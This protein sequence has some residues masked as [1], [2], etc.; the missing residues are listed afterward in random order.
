[1][2]HYENR[3]REG[4][5]F[6]IFAINSKTNWALLLTSIRAF[7]LPEFA[8]EAVRGTDFD[9]AVQIKID[10]DINTNATMA[11]GDLNC[12]IALRLAD[13]VERFKITVGKQG[14]FEQVG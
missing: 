9:D 1:M 13:T 6:I 7:F 2:S 11:A 4:Y 5:E 14:I 12:E 8:K 3:L 10:Q